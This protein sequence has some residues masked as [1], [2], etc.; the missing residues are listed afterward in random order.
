[1]SEPE[2][3]VTLERCFRLLTSG[4]VGG[5]GTS[6]GISGTKESTR[7]GSVPSSSG[8][9]TASS[10]TAATAGTLLGRCLRRQV[11]EAV[12]HRVTCMDHNLFDVIWPA[13]KK[14]SHAY[15]S[16]SSINSNVNVRERR[17]DFTY[18]PLRTTPPDPCDHLF[19]WNSSFS[20]LFLFSLK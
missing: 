6:R 1:M 4:I 16:N 11:F 17:F 14:Y 7:R 12:K 2:T 15:A 9:T 8:S 20:K 3:L 19:F 13:L 10:S 18:L 5:A